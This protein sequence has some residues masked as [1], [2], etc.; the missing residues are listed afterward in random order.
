MFALQREG[1]ASLKPRAVHVIVAYEAMPER[2]QCEKPYALLAR[3]LNCWD[4]N[5]DI[6]TP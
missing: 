1:L 2:G 5:A 4:G 3:L 6:R